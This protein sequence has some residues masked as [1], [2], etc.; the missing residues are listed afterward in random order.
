MVKHG[1]AERCSSH[2]RVVRTQMLASLQSPCLPLMKQD[3]VL[4]MRG[5][6]AASKAPKGAGS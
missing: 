4:E 1:D 5:G 2:D 3:I 6:Q